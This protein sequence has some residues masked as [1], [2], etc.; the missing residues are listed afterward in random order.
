MLALASVRT[1]FLERLHATLGEWAQPPVFAALFG[2]ASRGDMRPDSDID[3][4]LVRPDGLDAEHEADWHRNTDRLQQDTTAW[5]GNDA[6][7]LEMSSAEVRSGLA[8]DDPLLGAVRT[9]GRVLYGESRFWRGVS[10]A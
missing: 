5:T 10:R 9:E 6:R 2:S 1:V 7:V 4:F 8:A 3:I